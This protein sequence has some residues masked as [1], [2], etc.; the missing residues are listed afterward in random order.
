LAGR[1]FAVGKGVASGRAGGVSAD[2][3]AESDAFGQRSALKVVGAMR[4]AW[5]GY[6]QHAWGHDELKPISGRASDNWGGIGCTLVD[7]LDTLWL[8]G[9]KDEFD[10]AKRYAHTRKG[11]G[12]REGATTQPIASGLGTA[13]AS[14]AL[15]LT[16][17]ARALSR[18][19]SLVWHAAKVGGVELNFRPHRERLGVRNHHPRARRVAR[20]VRLQRRPGARGTRGFGGRA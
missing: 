12:E 4:H 10:E 6:Q 9:M 8:M 5:R 15:A 20:G 13:S 16:R 18:S 3:K 7:S 17:L 14:F 11:L 2:A 1:R 19:R